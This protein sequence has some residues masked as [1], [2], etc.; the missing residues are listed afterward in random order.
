MINIFLNVD[1]GGSILCC[2]HSNKYSDLP[3]WQTTHWFLH[4]PMNAPSSFTHFQD[5]QSIFTAISFYCLHLFN[6]QGYIPPLPLFPPTP[7]PYLPTYHT[8]QSHEWL[9]H[10]SQDVLPVTCSL[11]LLL[12][13]GGSLDIFV[14]ELL[15]SDR[16]LLLWPPHLV[17]FLGGHT[18]THHSTPVSHAQGSTLASLL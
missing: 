1:S 12:S 18:T 14:L 6:T 4:F 5:N 2:C 13:F 11:F 16:F 9:Q 3:K 8:C 10:T 15:F 17:L 7:T